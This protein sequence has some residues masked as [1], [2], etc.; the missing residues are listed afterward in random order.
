MTEYSAERNAPGLRWTSTRLAY[1]TSW[2]AWHWV[3]MAGLGVVVLVGA[4]MDAQVMQPAL[5]HILR[6]NADHVAFICYVIGLAAAVMMARAGWLARGAIGD[7]RLLVREGVVAAGLAAGWAGMG[8]MIAVA[9]WQAVGLAVAA[10]DTGYDGATPTAA[11]STQSAHLAAVV[12]LGIYLVT[13]MLAA[14]D[15]YTARNDVFQQKMNAL[16]RLTPARTALDEQEALLHRLAMNLSNA[17]HAFASI[18][19]EGELAKASQLALVNRLKQEAVLRFAYATQNPA[20]AGVSSTSN[21]LN[22]AAT[23]EVRDR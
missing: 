1:K 21:P 6:G 14:A 15:F 3:L 13:G 8:G 17:T 23:R 2:G 20:V 4:V 16:A 5:A 9:R 19:S 10:Q 11:P 18:V 22:P 12:F 7:P